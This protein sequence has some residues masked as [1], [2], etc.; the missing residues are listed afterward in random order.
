MYR[1][2]PVAIRQDQQDF[3]ENAM[4][5][6]SYGTARAKIWGGD[7]FADTGRL[8]AVIFSREAPWLEEGEVA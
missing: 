1:S 4:E 3:R 6:S 5:R 8:L 2:R 7:R